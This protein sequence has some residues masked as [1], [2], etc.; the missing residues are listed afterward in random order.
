[1]KKCNN[2][3]MLNAYAYYVKNLNS[4]PKKLNQCYNTVAIPS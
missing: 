2:S 4:L 3:T 1:M